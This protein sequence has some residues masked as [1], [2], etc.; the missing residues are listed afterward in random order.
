M[1]I[2]PLL[3]T[4]AAMATVAAVAFGAPALTGHP[5]A[6]SLSA[7]ATELPAVVPVPGMRIHVLSAGQQDARALAAKPTMT[8]PEAGVVPMLT[9]RGAG[10]AATTAL[11][12]SSAAAKGCKEP[13]CDLSRHGGPV[14]HSPHVYLLLWGPKWN[15]TGLPSQ[16]ASY[17][18]AFYS[19]LG[20]SSDSWSTITSQYADGS[21]HPTF[22]NPVFDPATD[23]FNDQTAP[24]SSVTPQDIGAEAL[25]IVSHITDTADAQVVVAAQSGTCF[26]DGFAGDSCKPAENAD[27]CGWHD[28]VAVPNSTGYLPYVNLPWQLDA[29]YGCGQNFVNGGSAGL[30]DGW[31]LVGG[32]EYAEAVTDPA[33]AT[34]Y[35]DTNDENGSTASGGEIADK[36]VW[37][38][39][40]WGLSDPFGDISLPVGTTTESFAMQSLWSNAADRCVMSTN[41][42]LYVAGLPAQK[43]VLGRAVSVQLSTVTN[44][45]FQ[46]YKATGLPADLSVGATTGRISGKPAVTAG[47]FKSRITISDYAKTVTIGVTWFVSSAPGAVRGYAGKC[48]DATRG[49][50]S[51]GNRIDIW[52]CTG[53]APQQFTFAANRELQLLGKCV[54]GGNTAFLEPCNDAADQA[55]TRLP[56]GE[57]RLAASGKC[58]TD[59][60]SSTANGT[61]LTLAACKNT[62]SQHWSLP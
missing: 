33:P 55:W 48:A 57:Y 25:K 39:L 2:R 21:G 59:P 32:H 16:V 22:G 60:G 62:A 52:S 61:G 10:P 6:G 9:G 38:G 40:P 54:T 28:A 49:R 20:T 53:K 43:A 41:P 15:T 27:Y 23:I 14:Q 44:T 17:L 5:N 58:L 30:L 34:G 12:T 31:S 50:N 36:C 46:K 26:S 56:N 45:G 3:T 1:K 11:I 29:N 47:T 42:K 19:G 8:G 51:N 24:Q 35:I 18:A 37:A 7:A 4:A 13:D